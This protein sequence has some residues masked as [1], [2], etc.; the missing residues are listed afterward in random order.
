M[1]A[2][3]EFLNEYPNVRVEIGG[4]TD[5]VGS[6]AVN[7]RISQERAQSVAEYVIS[8]GVPAN[9]VVSKGYGFEKPKASN[10]TAEGRAKNRRVD[11]TIIG[12]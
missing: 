5:N 10:R 6:A 9:R 11:F 1:N 12:I 7:K 2:L 3:I 8:Q 4:H